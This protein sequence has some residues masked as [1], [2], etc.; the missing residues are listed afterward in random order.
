MK[1]IIAA[2]VCATA[3]SGCGSL[4]N[5]FAPE[6]ISV[7][8]LGASGRV[9]ISAGANEPCV[10]T[11]TVL[12]VSPAGA[13]YGSRV[14]ADPPLDAYVIKSDYSDHQGSLSV[15][16]A[17]AGDYQIYPVTLNPMTEPIQIPKFEFSVEAGETVYVGELYATT[18]CGFNNRIEIRDSQVRDLDLARSRNP[19]FEHVAITSRLARPAGHIS[20]P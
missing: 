7:A 17:P 10:A 15:F 19:I 20:P 12:H 4:G 16:T 6:K 1:R 8:P 13:P 14:L 3:L 11:A 2:L 9:I 18:S 5:R